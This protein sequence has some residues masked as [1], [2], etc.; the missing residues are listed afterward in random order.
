MSKIQLENCEILAHKHLAGAQHILTLKSAKIAK[1]TKAGQFVHLTVDNSLEMRRPISI[2]S[3][4]IN[5]NSFDLLYKVVGVGTDKLASRQV[6]E[7][8]SVLGPIG[9]NFILNKKRPLLIG[10]GV[11]MPPMIAIAQSIAGNKNYDAFAVLASEVEF[12]FEVQT[13]KLKTACQVNATYDL[14]ENWGIATR[15]A[16][17]NPEVLKNSGIFNGFATDLAKKYLLSLSEKELNEVEIF[18]CGPTPMLQAVKNLAKEFN[19]QAQLSL[20]EHMACGVGGCAGCV[21]KTLEN[22]REYMRRVCVDG[23]IFNADEVF[24]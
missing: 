14:L 7:K 22:G 20:E 3:V 15:L 21:V 13:S 24:N 16:S 1:L 4:D 19:I 5:N 12:P 6:G 2:M 9:N 17:T 11:G 23:P 18:S 10:G 8:L